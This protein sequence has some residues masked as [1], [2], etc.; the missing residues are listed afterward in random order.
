MSLRITAR[1]AD[2]SS[3]VCGAM[4]V[5]AGSEALLTVT[6]SPRLY[7]VVRTPFLLT[8]GVATRLFFMLGE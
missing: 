8:M 5:G 7:T 2:V 3:V 4:L 1:S 6:F